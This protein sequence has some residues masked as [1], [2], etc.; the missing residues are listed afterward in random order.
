MTA[1]RKPRKT[2]TRKA[3]RDASKLVLQGAPKPEVTQTR[4]FSAKK[5][6]E[7]NKPKRLVRLPP[8][9]RTY[10]YVPAVDVP[11]KRRW[12]GQLTSG[13]PPLSDVAAILDCKWVQ[14]VPVMY[15]G[16]MAHMFLD[17]EGAMIGGILNWRAAAIVANRTVATTS[18]AKRA[19]YNDL[20]RI[21]PL[22][23]EVY[24][25]LDCGVIG[26]AVLWMGDFND[27]LKDEA[28]IES[29]LTKLGVTTP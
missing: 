24:L 8:Q 1:P 3:V 28:P 19:V 21:P 10:W 23:P 22:P 5:R 17:E 14:H 2:I 18:Y 9:E 20:T 16:K 25:R 13:V 11:E 26:K 15:G 12:M 29:I 27:R 4:R 7:S 6:N